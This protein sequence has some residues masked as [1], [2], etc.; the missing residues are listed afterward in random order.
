[1]APGEPDDGRK[2]DHLLG[3][4][5]PQQAQMNVAQ[6]SVYG[7]DD[8]QIDDVEDA[9]DLARHMAELAGVEVEV[10][11]KSRDS[12]DGVWTSV[13][14]SRGHGN[15]DVPADTTGL[16]REPDQGG[17]F[18]APPAE[19]KP[20]SAARHDADDIPFYPG[21]CRL[22][23]PLV[24]SPATGGR[25]CPCSRA[26]NCRSPKHG[27]KDATTDDVQ[28]G[29]WWRKWPD[30]NIGVATGSPGPTVLDIDDP[31]AAA[32]VL[33]RLLELNTPQ[34][35]TVRGRHLYFAGMD[36]G[37]INLGYGEL[38]GRGSYVV[39]PPSIHPSGNEYVWLAEPNG[40]LPRVPDWVAGGR[41]SKGAGVREPV[42]RVPHGERH[43]HLVDLAIRLVRSG[44]LD[45]GAIE[46]ALV[47]EYDAVCDKKPAA[48]PP[49]FARI[50]RDVVAG[51]I[52]ERE[53]ERAKK[54]KP[55]SSTRART[56]PAAPARDA[57][58]GDLRAF[59]AT[60]GGL[61]DVLR[62]DEVVRFGVDPGDA[63]HVRLSNGMRV[64]F[65]RQE[66]RDDAEGVAGR[67]DRRHVGRMPAA[68]FEGRRARRH[69][70][71]ALRYRRVDGRAT[72]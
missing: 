40:P 8:E 5:T 41:K 42:E 26:A 32:D 47:A 56:L 53:R 23:T 44:V 31:A 28:I 13:N 59:V 39:A 22:L 50:A 37:T 48:F 58:L 66:R 36:T 33:P 55:K 9:D 49:Y 45:E 6:L 18:A 20:A 67:M 68:E 70:L 34:A 14:F 30:A 17:L 3:F 29:Q 57:A 63:L 60:A 4:R 19:H 65:D 1:M 24:R 7:L 69:V 64:K 72:V 43:D 61:P 35:A 10:S 52:A 62:I 71:G 12:G 2:W 27:V 21:P 54:P 25:C 46:R 51:P 15:G 11:C 16:A 38:R